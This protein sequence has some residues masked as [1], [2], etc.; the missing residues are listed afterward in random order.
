MIWDT[1]GRHLFKHWIKLV[2]NWAEIE[3]FLKYQ[4]VFAKDVAELEAD[5]SADQCNR[6][7]CRAAYG[8][9]AL[10]QALSSPEQ[11]QVAHLTTIP[12][13]PSIVRCQYSCSCSI[14]R[15]QYSCT[16]HSIVRCQYSCTHYSI[17]RC[18]YS[19]HYS[20]VRCLT[21]LGHSA[22]HLPS[23]QQGCLSVSA[24]K[25]S[26]KLERCILFRWNFSFG[27]K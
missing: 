20:I 25:W 24:F 23:T 8:V 16:T 26:F 13:H 6:M 17:V 15:C 9:S 22:V 1:A 27:E 12:G 2:H 5:E 21:I 18:Q 3:V 7:E 14:E 11:H 19:W 4:K 10:T